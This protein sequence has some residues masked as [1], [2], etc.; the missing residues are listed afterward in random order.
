MPPRVC[1]SRR[2]EAEQSWELNLGTH[3]WS[4]GILAS[5]LI[6]RLKGSPWVTLLFTSTLFSKI[7]RIVLELPNYKEIVVKRPLIHTMIWNNLKIV[8][9]G[10]KKPEL[11]CYMFYDPFELIFGEDKT[12]GTETRSVVT[13]AWGG[14]ID[15]EGM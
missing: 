12:T 2:L 3:R 13:D 14:R 10:E 15:Y 5:I 4:G 11:K 8:I 1:V 6:A 7:L 9:L